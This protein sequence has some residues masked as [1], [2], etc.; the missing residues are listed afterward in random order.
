MSTLKRFHRLVA[1]SITG[2]DEDILT[3]HDNTTNGAIINPLHKF[4]KTDFCTRLSLIVRIKDIEQSDHQARTVA[5]Q[6]IRFLALPKS[7]LLII[8]ASAESAFAVQA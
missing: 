4:R 6:M 2:L 7:F 1:C 8:S 3:I 5:I